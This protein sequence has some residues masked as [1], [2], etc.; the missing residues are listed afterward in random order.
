MKKFTIPL[1]FIIMGWWLG[2]C[3]LVTYYKVQVN[4]FTDPQI[5]GQISPGATFFVIENKEAKNPLLENEIRAKIIKLLEQQGYQIAPFEKAE[6][7]L[8]FAYG[9]GSEQKVTV[10][11]PDYYPYDW[12]WGPGFGVGSGIALGGRSYIFG[13]P[14]FSYFPA[15]SKTLYDRWLLLNVVDGKYYREKK[16]EFRTLWVGEARSTGTSSDLRTAANYLLLAEFEQFGKNTGKAVP[17][18]ISEKDLRV[19]ALGK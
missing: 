19:K 14:F 5:P 11:M 4:G 8:L 2:G 17:V 10:V 16:G 7:Y 6:Y 3:A 18:D 12:Y 9:I 1:L 15:Y 13:G